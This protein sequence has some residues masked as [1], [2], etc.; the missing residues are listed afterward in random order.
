MLLVED[1]P[2][3]RELLL[4][5]I[6]DMGFAAEGA[7][8]A[9]EALR[10]LAAQ[11]AHILVLDLHLPGM[12]GLEFLQAVRQR[13]PGIMVVVL[14]GYG[15]LDAARQAIHLD[16]VDFLTKPCSLGDLEIALDRARKRL[17]PQGPPR[18]QP[19]VFFPHSQPQTHP[20]KPAPPGDSPD[21][22]ARRLDDLERGH[23]L[24]ALQRNQGNRTATARELGISLRTLYYRLSEYQKAGLLPDVE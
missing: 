8:S 4:R 24:A 6:P 12:S 23:I 18:T 9:E 17:A 11:L 19:E 16:V 21:L 14:T 22:N 5:A 10:K 1:E 3:L 20:P 2:R 13:W 15:D 7:G